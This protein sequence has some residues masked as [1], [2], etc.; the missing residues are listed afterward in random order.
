MIESVEINKDRK[1]GRGDTFFEYLQSLP[2]S[3]RMV[4]K[5]ISL[6]DSEA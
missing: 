1:A 4:D 3:P 6:V 2:V 5:F